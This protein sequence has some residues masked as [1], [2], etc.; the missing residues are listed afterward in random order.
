MTFTE[1]CERMDATFAVCPVQLE[2]AIYEAEKEA[3][4]ARIGYSLG[5]ERIGMSDVLRK[6]A[7]YEHLNT[8][9]ALWK[10]DYLTDE[11]VARWM[12]S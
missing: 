12:N 11:Q 3:D 1:L 9:R 7:I 5:D 10:E 6:V 2:N 4:R 8:I